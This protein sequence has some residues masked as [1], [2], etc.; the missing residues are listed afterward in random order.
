MIPLT[1]QAQQR[2]R[3]RQREKQARQAVELEAVEEQ[4]LALQ[5]ENEALARQNMVMEKMLAV[6]DAMMAVFTQ[7]DVVAE[8]PAQLEVLQDS[9]RQLVSAVERLPSQSEIDQLDQDLEPVLA[10]G[11]REEAGGGVG[12]GAAGVG[13]ALSMVPPESLLPGAERSGV[14]DALDGSALQ[15]VASVPQPTNELVRREIAAMQQPE[16][17]VAYYRRWQ[18]DLCQAWQAAQQAGLDE[19]SLRELHAQHKRMEEM[20]WHGE[21]SGFRELRAWARGGHGER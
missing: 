17:L 4:V 5:R 20:W 13:W 15:G 12:V 11:I 6:R 21:S 3:E 8:Q 14:A 19:A 7:T 9:G 10:A 16:D 2:F 18:V 1:L